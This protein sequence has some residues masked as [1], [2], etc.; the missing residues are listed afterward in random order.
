VERQG[1]ACRDFATLALRKCGTSGCM[2]LRPML[3]EIAPASAGKFV[4][5]DGKVGSLNVEA[6]T[7]SQV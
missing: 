6:P 7:Q 2:V 3:Q 4:D 5:G 1:Y